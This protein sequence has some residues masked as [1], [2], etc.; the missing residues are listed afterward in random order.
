M[1]CNA[2]MTKKEKQTPTN[3]LYAQGHRNMHVEYEYHNHA[4]TIY[5]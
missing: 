5:R 4:E 2:K 1:L 3:M